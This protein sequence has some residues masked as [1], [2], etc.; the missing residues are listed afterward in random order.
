MKTI[1]SLQAYEILAAE[2]KAGLRFADIYYEK[3]AGIPGIPAIN[4]KNLRKF[5]V[6]KKSFS[7]M[8]FDHTRSEVSFRVVV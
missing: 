4:I 7:F 3:I 6:N 1:K 5:V 8:I 2:V